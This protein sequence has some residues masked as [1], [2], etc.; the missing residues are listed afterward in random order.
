MFSKEFRKH[1][2]GF[3]GG[4]TELHTKLVADTLLDFAIH[5]TVLTLSDTPELNPNIKI[6]K[7]P[8]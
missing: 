1:F 4:F 6:K 7:I 8:M 2:K 5:R 3:G